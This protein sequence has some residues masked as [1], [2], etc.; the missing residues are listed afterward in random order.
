LTPGADSKGVWLNVTRLWPHF[1][2]V[3]M[4]LEIL[5][6]LLEQAQNV[7][8]ETGQCPTAV[9]ALTWAIDEISLRKNRSSPSRR[10]KQQPLPQ[11]ALDQ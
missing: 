3:Q 2:G 5:K 6:R 10:Q 8:A 11:P 1:L 4:E 7:E 9:E